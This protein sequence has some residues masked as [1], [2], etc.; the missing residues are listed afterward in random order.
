M[1]TIKKEKV[2][3]VIGVVEQ[4]KV[5]EKT[6]FIIMPIAD[7]P[8]YEKGHFKRVYDYL[9]KPACEAAG[10]KA[11]R[12]DDS[13]ASHLIMF[14]ILKSIVECDM[15]IC[16]L[17]TKNANVFYELG[18]RQAF[19]KKTILITDGKEKAPFDIAGFRYVQ[20]SS[21]LRI[22]E[23]TTDI[24]NIKNMLNETKNAPESDVNSIV[25]LL[26]MEPAKIDKKDLNTEESI[27]FKMLI[28]MNDRLDKLAE[29]KNILPDV[30]I[31]HWSPT[32]HTRDI[33]NN[34]IITLYDILNS[35]HL[36]IHDYYYSDGLANLGE[37][38]GI[39]PETVIFSEVGPVLRDD[40]RMK[41][42]KAHRMNP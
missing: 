13:K 40:F 20:Y 10:Y 1:S 21:T 18:L 31:S 38:I 37:I 8:D 17:T 6:C 35:N 12:A 4:P 19:N 28:S 23:T 16:D 42:I 7:H 30:N 9:I 25:K 33:N 11:I 41:S 27:L 5:K 24:N 3:D 36:N 26:E 34:I 29:N 15:A 14:D 22:D 39:T 32:S 2:T